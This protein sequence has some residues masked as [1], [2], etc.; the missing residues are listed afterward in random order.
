MVWMTLVFSTSTTILTVIQVIFFNACDGIVAELSR[1]VEAETR[2]SY[3]AVKD[4]Q[5]NLTDED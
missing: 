2:L 1:S 3:S 4:E 5:I